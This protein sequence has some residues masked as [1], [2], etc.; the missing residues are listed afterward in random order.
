MMNIVKFGD[1]VYRCMF[2]NTVCDARVLATLLLFAKEKYMDAR[3]G[4]CPFCGKEFRN[5][6]ALKYHVLRGGCSV[7]LKHF[8]EELYERYINEM[9]GKSMDEIM[10]IIHRET[11]FENVWIPR[12]GR[13]RWLRW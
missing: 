5:P 7:M 6:S 2:R 8:S 13:R 12:R 9:M 11:N 3:M 1:M 4:K 10:D